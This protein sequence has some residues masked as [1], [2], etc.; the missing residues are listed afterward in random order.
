MATPE[1]SRRSVSPQVGP[2]C[3]CCGSTA[4]SQLTVP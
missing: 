2:Q 1:E 3:P 4:I